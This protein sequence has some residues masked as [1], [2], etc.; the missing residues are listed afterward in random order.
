MA[1]FTIFKS[2]FPRQ[3]SRRKP[4]ARSASSSCI[5]AIRS[6]RPSITQLVSSLHL[7]K[8]IRH[9]RGRLTPWTRLHRR[10][11]T[12]WKTAG[13]RE[14][15]SARSRKHAKFDRLLSDCTSLVMLRKPGKTKTRH[16]SRMQPWSNLAPAWL[17]VN[18]TAWRP[19]QGHRLLLPELVDLRRIK[20][21]GDCDMC[22]TTSSLAIKPN[23]VASR[24]WTSSSSTVETRSDSGRNW[25][26]SS[27]ATRTS[28]YSSRSCASSSGACCSTRSSS[29]NFTSPLRS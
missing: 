29:R 25:T 10:R 14:R 22:W 11:S 24:R 28:S 20:T 5:D 15:C 8:I 13:R 27:H 3:P 19:A 17:A 4:P 1:R 18:A 23:H 26:T 12:S 2:Q 6:D 21:T 16:K 7:S 9:Q